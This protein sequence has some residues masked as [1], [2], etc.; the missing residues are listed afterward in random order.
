MRACFHNGALEL[1]EGI[2]IKRSL[3]R[4]VIAIISDGDALPETAEK[5]H[6][7]IGRGC[8][9]VAVRGFQNENL[10]ARLAML[11]AERPA[12]CAYGVVA[13]RGIDDVFPLVVFTPAA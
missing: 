11:V 10:A 8:L 13:I 4:S 9:A 12:D 1:W 6:Q 5:V 2:Q 3:P 7:E